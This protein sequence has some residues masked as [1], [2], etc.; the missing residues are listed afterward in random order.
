MPAILSDKP[1]DRPKLIMIGIP[2]FGMVSMYWH[3]QLADML[4]IGK[5]MNRAFV[6]RVVKGHTVAEARN[7]IVEQI[8]EIEES[9]SADVTHVFFLDDDVLVQTDTLIRLLS[10]DRPIVSGLYFAKTEAP[11]PLLFSK[12]FAGPD[13]RYAG[14]D[15]PKELVDCYGHGM[16]CTLI[17]R[18][19]FDAVEAPW[20]S[21][22]TGRLDGQEY[23]SHTEDMFFLEK[24][25]A[26]GFQPAVD[27]GALVAHYCSKTDQVFPRW[28]KGEEV[29]A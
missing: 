24:A 2:T 8:P 23:L 20:F 18:R 29:A 17:E 6:E 15:R 22:E 26:A 28:L 5:P 11:Q 4:R 9:F 1:K 13:M 12:P 10:H 19:V 27:T 21:T 25:A 7:M 14:K 16:G 3:L